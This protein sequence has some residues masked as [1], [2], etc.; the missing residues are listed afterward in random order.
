V[1]GGRLA[2]L[3]VGALER[4]RGER[5][6]FLAAA[7]ANEPEARAEVERLLAAHEAAG[8]F[9]EAPIDPAS[10][11]ALIEPSADSPAVEGG[12]IGPYRLVREIGQG[13]MGHVYLAERDDG[14]FEQ[15]VAL[16]VVDAGRDSEERLRRFLRERRILA[17]LRHPFIAQL[18]DGGIASDGRPYFAMELVDGTPITRYCDERSASVEERL[19]LLCDVCRAVQHAHAALVV[20]RDLKP[21]NV[22][23][24]ARGEVKL[25]DFGIATFMAGAD[26]DEP[27]ITAPAEGVMTPQYGSPEQF[28]G[29]PVTTASDVYQLGL[30]AYEL[31]AGRRPYELRG[32]S[33]DVASRLVC[34][35]MP[36]PPSR[37]SGKATGRGE[38]GGGSRRPARL[39][40][41]LD[42]IVLK[43][44]QKDPAARYASADQL[45]EDLERYLAGLPIL[46]RAPTLGYRLRKLVARHWVATAALVAGVALMVS[47]AA[48]FTV[49]LIHERNQTRAAAEE[50][51]RQR[52]ES[53]EVTDF[54]VE[55][56]EVADPAV[57]GRTVTARELLDRGAAR[58]ERDLGEQPQARARLLYAIGST[59]RRLGLLDEAEV[60]LGQSL[61]IR[62]RA[63]GEPLELAE[64]LEGLGLVAWRQRRLDEAEGFYLRSLAL[65]ELLVEP[66]HRSLGRLS[67]HLGNLRRAQGRLPEAETLL[68]RSVDILEQVES[69]GGEMAEILAALGLVLKDRGSYAEAASTLG[70]A[71]ALLESSVAAEHP[72]LA[73][74]LSSLATLHSELGRHDLSL[75]L[76]ERAYRIREA[77]YGPRDP[78]AL[79]ILNNLGI[80]YLELGQLDRADDA[81]ARVEAAFLAARTPRPEIGNVVLNRGNVALERAR[82]VEAESFYRR[83]LEILQSALPPGHPQIGLA[84]NNLGEA[85]LAQARLDE[86]EALFDRSLAIFETALGAE[87]LFVSWPVLNLGR[88]RRRG[89]QMERAEPLYRRALEI[90]RRHLELDSPDREEVET[91]WSELQRELGRPDAAQGGL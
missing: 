89:G 49:R 40:G 21:S 76:F 3:F 43:A 70:R 67:F 47:M 66:R 14:M 83:G 7:A 44:L 78:E 36:A 38:Q 11:A 81:L 87:H 32:A 15:Q 61:A 69:Q 86:A 50:A 19:R 85:V 74:L 52:L 79:A 55:L 46:A 16:K 56:F 91:E 54:L 65:F 30:L 73:V 31:V 1:S 2:E 57:E 34:E 68:R 90:R 27:S 10:A 59:Y 25:L 58:I 62:E 24:S 77:A 6:L 64:T 42:T 13:G 88:L 75:P 35:T 5:R 63:G 22:L 71:I 20:H 9:L 12:R 51:E 60:L 41:E 23:V 84:L 29:E 39:G 26:A 37:A 8:R 82:Y 45:R 18:Y 28:R 4:P 48:L 53:E 72:R 80:D 33:P 17:R